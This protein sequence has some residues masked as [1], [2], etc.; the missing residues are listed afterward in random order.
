MSD[1]VE[2]QTPHHN[3]PNRDPS[4]YLKW[5]ATSGR[6]MVQKRTLDGCFHNCHAAAP[7]FLAL[8]VSRRN[9]IRRPA[10]RFCAIDRA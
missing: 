1:A 6:T 10:A 7:R 3:P 5:E 4:E 8:P 2:K 9:V